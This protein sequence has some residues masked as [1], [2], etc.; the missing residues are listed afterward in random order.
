LFVSIKKGQ[1]KKVQEEAAARRKAFKWGMEL[2]RAKDYTLLIHE[3]FT[4]T[5]SSIYLISSLRTLVLKRIAEEQNLLYRSVEDYPDISRRLIKMRNEVASARGEKI[6]SLSPNPLFVYLWD[7]LSNNDLRLN[8]IESVYVTLM[9]ADSP[10]VILT[11]I[12]LRKCS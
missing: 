7:V 12:F 2:L 11:Q 10:Q 8:E 6:V 3:L 5:D 1:S 9:M 4:N